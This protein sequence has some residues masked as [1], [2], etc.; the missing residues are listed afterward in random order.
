MQDFPRPDAALG[1]RPF[2]FRI[3]MLLL[4][5][6]VVMALPAFRGGLLGYDDENLLRGP[7]GALQRGFSSF[8]TGLYYYAYLPLYGLSFRIDGWIFGD[9]PLAFHVV[10]ALWHAAAGY[11]A[12]CV[13][14]LL[15]GH[16]VGALFGALLFVLH[17]LHV[18]SVAWIA[19]RKEVLSGFLFFLAWLLHLKGEEG[20]RG[21]TIFSCAA[22]LAACFAKASAVVLPGCLV[23]AA[24]LLPRYAGARG[25]SVRRAIPMLLVALLPIAVHLFV[26]EEQGVVKEAAGFASRLYGGAS[27]WGASILQTILPFGLSVDYPGPPSPFHLLPLAAAIALLLLLA[28]RAPHAAAGIAIFLVAISPFNGVFPATDLLRADR[29]LYLPLFGFALVAGW[30]VAT[31]RNGALLA[32]MVAI[33]FAALSFVSAS[34]FLSDEVLWTRTL[35]SHDGSALAWIQRGLDR[36][37]RALTSQPRDDALLD[38]AIGDLEAGLGRARI[39]EHRAKAEAG[40]ALALQQRGREQE[41]IA[42]A[43]D[44]LRRTAGSRSRGADLFRAAVLRNRA[45]AWFDLGMPADAARDLAESARLR[46]TYDVLV[47]LGKACIAAGRPEE[48]RRAL[49]SA[50]GLDRRNPE[51]WLYLAKAAQVRGDR[52]AR[53]RMLDEASV[54]APADERVA[55]EWVEFWLD[56]ESPD[57]LRASKALEALPADSHARRRLEARVEARRAIFLFRRG[58]LEQAL[59]VARE[60]RRRGV[61]PSLELYELGNLFTEAGEFDEAVRCFQG[62]GDALSRR[63]AGQDAVARAYSLKGYA[64]WC[65]DDLPGA[66]AAFRAALGVHPQ[67]IDAGA[68]PLSGELADLA[69]A[70]S[71]ELIL[72]AIAAVAGDSVRGE[73]VA[74]ALLAQDP[75]QEQRNSVHRL[76]GMLRV[77]VSRD[78]E[79]AESDFQTI[80]NVAPG[81]RW[82]TL[83]LA[84]VLTSSGVGWLRTAEV[85]RSVERREQGRRLLDRAQEVLSELI[86]REPGF[87]EARVA[88]GEARFAADDLVGAKDDYAFVRGRDP[89]MKEVL[90]KEA[91]LHRL[92]Y[93]RGGEVKNLQAATDLLTRALEID[94]NYFDGL[95]ELGNVQHLLYD[96]QDEES[97]ERKRAF[98]DAI[99][100]YRRAMALN[101]RNPGPRREWAAICLKAAQ[102]AEAGDEVA[103]A[104]ELLRRVEDQAGELPDVLRAR[105][106][107]NLRLDYGDRS[108]RKPDEIFEQVRRCLDRLDASEPGAPDLPFLRSQYHRQRGYSYYWTWVKLREPALKEKARRLAVEQWREA[109]RVSPD[110]PE[111][112]SLRDRLHE[113]APEEIEFD[114]TMAEQAYRE[115]VTAFQ[116]RRWSDAALKFREAERFLPEVAEIRFYLAMAQVRTGQLEEAQGRLQ[117]IA[118]GP[119]AVRFPESMFELG[120]LFA[121]RRDKAT[122]RIWYQRFLAA[123]ESAG[124]TQEESVGA[125]RRALEALR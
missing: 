19:G 54:R 53:Q 124:R 24:L 78:F 68:A 90:L 3:A 109:L 26:G 82:A 97:R 9:S 116:E 87:L 44:A 11:A 23:A 29:Y 56:G 22:F 111:N 2:R 25:K 101:P 96:R 107:M 15:L 79:G 61:E 18:E 60:A 72:L 94:P 88:R 93:V 6:S 67:V 31:A 41:A 105:V 62:A 110:D 114:R 28:R 121:V 99:V 17:P 58:D 42:R 30:A 86:A 49:E 38:A 103:R 10:N 108:K 37:A 16:R 34:R 104:D 120:N 71:S 35:G 47:D 63:R 40:L 52:A 102:E 106:R 91:A 7:D 14:G 115:G 125:A 117:E 76:R 123:M 74:T 36:T 5:A 8:F 118:N 66:V 70:A 73:T 21:A 119:D 84:Q 48:A 100:C 113:I 39:E 33:A 20:M 13:L 43:E 64:L 50:A 81:D 83:R 45:L 69:G 59:S 65:R 98:N 80:L 46:P 12:F 77:F 75:S 85:A 1:P 27:A 32:G 122:A 55:A 57:H 51:P 112:R 4:V 89:E 92:V 95:F